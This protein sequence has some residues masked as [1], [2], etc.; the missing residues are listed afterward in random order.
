MEKEKHKTVEWFQRLEKD[1]QSALPDISEEQWQL[2]RQKLPFEKQVI[3][4]YRW[5]HATALQ[6]DVTNEPQLAYNAL[7]GVLVALRDRM[8]LAEVFQLA[9]QMPVHIR[10]IYFEGYNPVDKPQK[11]HSSE[12]L[13]RI[14]QGMGPRAV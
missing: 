14:E 10:G 1:P 2:L 13:H 5:I 6:L 11:F 7:R 12:L 4:S 9:A 8:P 3:Q